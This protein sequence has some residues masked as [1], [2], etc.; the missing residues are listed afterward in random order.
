MRRKAENGDKTRYQTV[1]GS[2]EKTGSVAA[3][4]A[5]LHFTEEMKNRLLGLGFGWTELTLYVGYGTFSPVRC[6][7]I[8][9]HAMHPEYVEISADCANTIRQAKADGRPIV[10]VGLL[11]NFHLPESTRLMLVSAFAN[12]QYVLDAYAMAVER[13]YRFF[14]YGDA[15]LIS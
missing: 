4:T 6:Q 8:R 13:K 11:T 1:Y 2:P 5:G 15:M 9:K 12:R 3:P 7:D 14:S 10:A